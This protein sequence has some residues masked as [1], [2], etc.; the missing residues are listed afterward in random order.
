VDG[1]AE[2]KEGSSEVES[3]GL[4][5]EEEDARE[6]GGGEGKREEK[7]GEGSPEEGVVPEEEVGVAT[8]VSL[9]GGDV[10][11]GEGFGVALVDG[12][13]CTLLEGVG[14]E[15]SGGRLEM[16]ESVSSIAS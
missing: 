3:A 4:P 9:L 10:S 14:G 2:V 6:G 16:V 15:D 7:G 11:L 1:G 12:A 5:D 13:G 8:G